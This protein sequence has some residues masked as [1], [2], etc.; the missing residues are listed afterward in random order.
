MIGETG[1]VAQTLAGS[2][3]SVLAGSSTHLKARDLF[4]G[5]ENKPKGPLLIEPS[6]FALLLLLSLQESRTVR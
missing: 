2:P 1:Q 4:S 5:R 3:A 6:S